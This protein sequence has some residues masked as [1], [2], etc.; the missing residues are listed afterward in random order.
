MGSY[1][2]MKVPAENDS[3]TIVAR[4]SEIASR[5]A[6]RG[7]VAPI[8][9][10]GRGASSADL[11]DTSYAIIPLRLDTRMKLTAAC[12]IV[13]SGTFAAQAADKALQPR[14]LTTEHLR[15]AAA[16]AGFKVVEVMAD[17]PSAVRSSLPWKVPAYD[18]PQLA[19]LREKYSLP[20]VIAKAKDEWQAQLLLKDW[21][22]RQIPGGTPASSPS[23][24]DAI[25]TRAAKGERFW[26]TYYAITYTECA[27]ALG[28]QARKLGIDRKHG[29]EGMGSTHHGVS[30]VWSNQ[31]RKWVVIDPQ[32]NLHYEKDGAPLSAWDIRREWLSKRG[33]GVE[34]VIGVPPRTVKKNPGITWWSRPDE[35]ETATYFWVYI[36]QPGPRSMHYLPLDDSNAG[37]VWYQNNSETQQGRLHI[38]YLR[39]QFVPVRNV[40]EAWWTVGVVE[41]KIAGASSGTIRLRLV[42]HDPYGT[43]FEMSLDGS[44]WNRVADPA[45]A[46]WPLKPGW[47]TLRL[48]TTGQR[49]ITGP[50]AAAAILLERP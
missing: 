25:L 31:F 14:P 32:S 5:P 46:A 17:V 7:A 8:R 44:T 11:G 15:S 27:L 41:P 50:E 1:Q 10:I 34:R 12:L 36:T 33:V 21:V 18:D 29:P 45:S 3:L 22:Y 26:C 35:D 28:W 48:R 38:G 4:C 49:G 39:N 2:E 30:E 37:A 19:S 47:N 42:T 40:A 6:F 20:A 24:A 23:T 9:P 13:L 43:G 16:A